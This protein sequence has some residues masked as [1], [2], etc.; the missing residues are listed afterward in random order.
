MENNEEQKPTTV[1]DVSAAY[2]KD[3]QFS[4][5]TVIQTR[6]TK[7]EHLEELQN[8]MIDACQQIEKK[9]WPKEEKVIQIP[10]GSGTENGN[11]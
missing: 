9:F 11:N 1:R 8:R 2:E 7:P 4:I 5:H 3:G 10:S 6:W